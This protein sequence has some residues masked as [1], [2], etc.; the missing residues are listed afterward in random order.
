[1][2]TT[3]LICA[4]QIENEKYSMQ[5]M[6]YLHKYSK[7]ATTPEFSK[8]RIDL[9][10]G[11]NCTALHYAAYLGHLE[12]CKFLIENKLVNLE[13]INNYKELAINMVKPE[14]LDL[15]EYL[16]KFMSEAKI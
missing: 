11:I 2:K 15:R 10:D 12:C 13:Q 14:N 1:M 9:T 6:K 5:M 4:S 3:A 16:S 7:L 8:I